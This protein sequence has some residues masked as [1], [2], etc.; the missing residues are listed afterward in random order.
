VCIG[1]CGLCGVEDS[2]L[3]YDMCFDCSYLEERNMSDR[4]HSHGFPKGEERGYCIYC[5]NPLVKVSG[6][7]CV[8]LGCHI[9]PYN[10][11]F[12]KPAKDK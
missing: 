2:H 7:D 11:T 10:Y 5:N 8:C 12:V 1:M 9:E 6:S 3:Y 4:T